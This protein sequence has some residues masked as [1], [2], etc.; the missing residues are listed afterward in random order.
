VF[1][2][3]NTTLDGITPSHL[4]GRI[5]TTELDALPSSDAAGSPAAPPAADTDRRSGHTQDTFAVRP[6]MAVGTRRTQRPMPL[7]R[8][9]S[10]VP[11]V[12][13]RDISEVM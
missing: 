13:Q 6:R 10:A 8:V 9:I 2:E 3:L 1:G 5:G 4:C 11:A 7:T 12:P